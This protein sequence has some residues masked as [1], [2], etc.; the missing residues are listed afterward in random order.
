MTELKPIFTVPSRDEI[1]ARIK[2]MDNVRAFHKLDAHIMLTEPLKY[3]RRFDSANWLF[4]WLV[5]DLEDD[6]EYIQY[7]NI[8]ITHG[9]GVAKVRSICDHG[10]FRSSATVSPADFPLERLALRAVCEDNF[11]HISL[12]A[13]S[14]DESYWRHVDS[15]CEPGGFS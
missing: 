5:S 6:F 4:E 7:L 1:V 11:W 14:V 3:L 15:G 9:G 2:S 12:I 8:S 13:D 10:V